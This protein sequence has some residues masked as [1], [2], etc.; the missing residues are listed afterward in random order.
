MWRKIGVDVQLQQIE[1]NTFNSVRL[2]NHDFQA[3]IGTWI[4]G[5]TPDFLKQLYGTGE[6][7]NI[8][9]Y[10]NPKVDS[11]IDLAQHQS[12]EPAA[13]PY[14]QKAAVQIT[15]DQPYTWLYYF[16]VV[17]PVRNHLKGVRID[18]FGAYQNTWEWWVPRSQQR[19]S[20]AAMDSA[21]PSGAA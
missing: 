18:T 3:A 10:S 21:A 13:A 15:A 8:T 6:P 14:W 16:D 9:Q 19:G 4:Q 20:R 1:F 11:L 7:Y 2:L 17:D 12:S 5:L